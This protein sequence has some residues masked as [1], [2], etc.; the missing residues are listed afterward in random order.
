LNECN[1]STGNFNGT[2]TFPSL[3]A[4]QITENGLTQGYDPADS[5][6]GRRASQFLGRRRH[7]PARCSISLTWAFTERMTGGCALITSA[8]ACGFERRRYSRPSRL[9]SRMVWLGARPRKSRPRPS[10]APLGISITALR[11]VYLL[12]AER[13]NGINHKSSFL[14]SPACLTPPQQSTP[15]PAVGLS[16]LLRLRPVSNITTV[17]PNLERHS[18]DYRGAWH[19]RHL[20]KSPPF[21]HLSHRR[22]GQQ[23]LTRHQCNAPGTYPLGD[24]SVGT[25]PVNTLIN[26]QSL[27]HLSV[28]SGYILIGRINW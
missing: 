13:L 20:S 6:Q 14:T 22:P 26:H 27:E 19:Q 16:G 17:D 3:T 7:T 24:P 1:S 10:C 15:K 8:W 5:G 25:S 12:N 21:R 9:R 28:Q 18:S 2:F 11:R 4:Y 23:I